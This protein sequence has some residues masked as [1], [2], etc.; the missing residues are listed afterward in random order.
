MVDLTRR[1]FLFGL[2]A[3]PLVVPVVKHFVMP[4]LEMARTPTW[5]RLANARAYIDAHEP[6]GSACY[7]FS[8]MPR[9]DG[10]LCERIRNLDLYP[11]DGYRS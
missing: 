4:K 8:L 3:V 2:A 6:G 11:I 7:R 9:G 5:D 10:V 1:R